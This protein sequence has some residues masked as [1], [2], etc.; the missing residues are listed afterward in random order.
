MSNPAQ[1][2]LIWMLRRVNER[3]EWLGFVRLTDGG[4]RIVGGP[5]G[6]HLTGHGESWKDKYASLLAAGFLVGGRPRVLPPLD[7]YDSEFLRSFEVE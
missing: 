1:N 2:E 5:T 4:A 6:S 3:D 7:A